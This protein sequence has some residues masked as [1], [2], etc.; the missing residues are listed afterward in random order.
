MPGE[1]ESFRRLC[2]VIDY[3]QALKHGIAKDTGSLHVLIEAH[4]RSHKLVYG[5]DHWTPKWH[6]TLHLAGQVEQECGYVFDTICNERAHQTCKSFG[7]TIK[8]LAYFEEY[9]LSRS[10]A[11]Q[12]NELSK[13]QGSHVGLDGHTVWSSEFEALTAAKMSCNGM[14]ISRGDYVI[15][16]EGAIVEVKFCGM[17]NGNLFLLGDACQTKERTATSVVVVRRLALH[18]VWVKDNQDVTCAR[19]W[20]PIPESE[21]I[22]V[23]V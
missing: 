6:A 12:L 2:A 15:T 18:L 19:C 9:V 22:R 16:R 13:F 7:D 10:L 11:N 8:N 1:V 21:E 14:H 3:I 20:K 5:N 17:T 23:I 4:L